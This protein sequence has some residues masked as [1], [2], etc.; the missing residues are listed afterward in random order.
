VSNPSK[1]RGTAA[2]SAVVN[3]LRRF[4]PHV[5][6]RAL[7]GAYD[8]GDIAGIPSVVI[9]VKAHAKYAFPEWVDEAE[10]ERIND[11]AQIGVVW[12]KRRGSTNP[13]AWV[14]AMS[15]DQFAWLLAEAGFLPPRHEE[16]P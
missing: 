8:R 10:R 2:E 1:Q 5:E 6:R 15:G 16:T 11:N 4:T 13:G 14:V 9:E 7:S 3:Y 12:A